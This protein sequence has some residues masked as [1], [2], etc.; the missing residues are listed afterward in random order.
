MAKRI[1]F[2]AQHDAALLRAAGYIHD[3]VP[4]H[5][6]DI[7]GSAGTCSTFQPA[8]HVW[9]LDNE[10]QIHEIIV[11]KGEVI[12]AEETEYWVGQS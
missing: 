6:D 2:D 3:F 8:M 11:A 12:F 5:W 1:Q 7:S 10:D 4:A 9:T